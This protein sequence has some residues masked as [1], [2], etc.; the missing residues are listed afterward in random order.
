MPDRNYKLELV[1]MKGIKGN[2]ELTREDSHLK[3]D[4]CDAI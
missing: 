1:F 3:V 4:F 2:L